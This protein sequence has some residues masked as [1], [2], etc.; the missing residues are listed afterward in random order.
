MI[1]MATAL[2]ISFNPLRHYE[3]ALLDSFGQPATPIATVELEAILAF[4]CILGLI[5]ARKEIG[6]QTKTTRKRHRRQ[7]QPSSVALNTEDSHHPLRFLLIIVLC[8]GVFLSAAVASL[9]F[10]FSLT[11]N[12]AEWYDSGVPSDLSAYYWVQNLPMIY[13][14]LPM[15]SVPLAL[16]VFCLFFLFVVIFKKKDY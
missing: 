12:F 1:C 10:H 14:K 6:V 15:I 8:I 16:S 11:T 4:V 2:T 9:I 7:T 5:W 3:F 13:S